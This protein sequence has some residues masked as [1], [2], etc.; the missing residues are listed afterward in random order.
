M[1]TRIAKA[2]IVLLACLVTSACEEENENWGNP[3]KVCEAPD[4]ACWG[5]ECEQDGCSPRMTDEIDPAGIP[6]CTDG[7]VLYVTWVAGRFYEIYLVCDVPYDGG[8]IYWGSLGPWEAR[9]LV[10]ETT[11]Q[12]PRAKPSSYYECVNG[13]CQNTNTDLYPRDIVIGPYADSLCYA[14]FTRAETLDFVVNPIAI[15]EEI[16]AACPGDWDEPCTGELP[17]YCWEG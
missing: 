5:W 11:A 7:T 8:P 16:Y 15:S 17:D 12:C 9:P 13:L 1:K 14:P 2:G 4:G 6:D 3:T 10:C